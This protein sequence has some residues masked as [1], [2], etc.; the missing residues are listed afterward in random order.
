MYDLIVMPMTLSEGRLVQP[1]PG[2]KVVHAPRRAVRSRSEDIL[3]LSMTV[4]DNENFNLNAKESWLDDLVQSFFRTSGS[5]TTALRMLIESINLMMLEQ[6]LQMVQDNKTA[7]GAINLMAIHRQ[8]VYIAQSGSTHA[9]VLSH[10]TFDHFYD[11]NQ[12][13]RGLGFSRTPAIRYFQAD[14]GKGAYLFVTDTPPKSWTVEGLF[15]GEF[16]NREQLR[17][18][19]LNQAPQDFSMALIEIKP[20]E[21]KIQ[22]IAAPGSPE[23]A[24]IVDETAD[25]ATKGAVEAADQVVEP[26]SVDESAGSLE[27]T[28]EINLEKSQTVDTE[29]TAEVMAWEIIPQPEVDSHTLDTPQSDELTEA[30][31]ATESEVL[32]S[33]GEVREKEDVV[34]PD[35]IEI[36]EEMEEIEET[37]KPGRPQQIRVAEDEEMGQGSLTEQ[38]TSDLAMSPEEEILPASREKTVRGRASR[39]QKRDLAADLENFKRG[40]KHWKNKTSDKILNSLSGFFKWWH[41]TRDKLNAFF[42]KLI[43]RS[44]VGQDSSIQ[45]SRGTM[46]FIAVMVP[47]AVVVIAVGF[48]LARGRSQQYDYYYEQAQVASANALAAL[49][50]LEKQNFWTAALDYLDQAETVRETN[51]IDQL[52]DQAQDALDG[53]EG[54]VRIAYQPAIMDV[55]NEDILITRIVPYGSDLYLL[56]SNAGQVIHAVMGDQG[57]EIDLDFSCEPGSY[58]GGVVNTFVDMVSMPINNPYQAQILAV[59]ANGGVAFCGKGQGPIVQA[60]PSQGLNTIE[61][62]RVAYDVNYLYVLDPLANNILVYR[63]DNYQFIEPP[64]LYFEGEDLA[65][66]PDLSQIV[67][68]AVNGSDLYL[69]RAD[70]MVVNCRTSGVSENPVTCENPVTYEDGRV[71]REEQPVVMPNSSFN[72]ILYTA[73]P[74]PALSFLDATNADIY[75]FSVRFRLYKLLRPD[76]G[77]FELGSTNATAFTIGSNRFAYIAF[78]NQVFY[79]YIE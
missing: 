25:D 78:G 16:P 2:L 29:I 41:T 15:P 30:A 69:L 18:R 74:D 46:L 26:T 22:T 68:L 52:R 12:A 27:D 34:Q 61:I 33:L 55:L 11:A 28:Q 63:P 66:M 1:E 14:I 42:N 5:V 54:A 10:H 36:P 49:D 73:P 75:R 9:F 21:G 71:G 17:R 79:A 72:S 77:D 53:L 57:Y 7:K 38:Q 43:S 67:D 48:Y 65:D 58:L 13:D 45:L 62:Q 3:I 37:E 8:A 32:E 76:L 4:D 20:G 70:G 44:S 6:N 39:Q 59:D 47:L 19:L 56:D 35:D 51:E 31:T 50:P 23:S 24:Q 40:F 64:T 60:L